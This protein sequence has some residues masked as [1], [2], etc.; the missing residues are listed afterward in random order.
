[1]FLA[2]VT[3]PDIGFAVNNLS[4]FI[5]KHDKTHWQAA[6]RVLA[7]LA[8]TVDTGIEYSFN[9][10]ESKLVGYSDAAFAN[11]LETRRSTTGYVFCMANGPVTWSCQR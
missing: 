1:M 5:N 6:K 11:D 2:T 4:K 10:N 8:G 7:Y 3:R 9:G